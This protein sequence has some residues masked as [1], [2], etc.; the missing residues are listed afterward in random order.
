LN[1][2]TSCYLPQGAHKMDDVAGRR[3]G[4]LVNVP[5]SIPHCRCVSKTIMSQKFKQN[6]FQK[7]NSILLSDPR[8]S[9]P[10]ECSSCSQSRYAVSHTSLPLHDCEK[11]VGK[12]SSTKRFEN[13]TRCP[14]AIRR[15]V[16]RLC[17]PL[18]QS[19]PW[20]ER[21]ENGWQHSWAGSG[22]VKRTS[23]C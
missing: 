9:W 18:W 1:P 4:V 10:H 21:H 17:R 12:K 23:L 15:G 19:M 6:D 16:A 3:E 2:V 14:A 7:S 11:R 8:T 22:E 20:F 13:Q 5:C